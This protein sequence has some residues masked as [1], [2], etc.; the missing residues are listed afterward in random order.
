MNKENFK[1]AQSPSGPFKHYI[2]I[3]LNPFIKPS[4]SNL[5]SSTHSLLVFISFL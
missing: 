4:V 1:D 2:L 3:S 5:P